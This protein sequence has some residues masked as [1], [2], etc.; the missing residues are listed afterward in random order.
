MYLP[1]QRINPRYIAYVY[2][3][4]F[5]RGVDMKG[6]LILLAVTGLCFGQVTYEGRGADAKWLNIKSPTIIP[7]PHA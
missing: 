5:E 4:F 7:I 2:R 3:L 6:V 1:I